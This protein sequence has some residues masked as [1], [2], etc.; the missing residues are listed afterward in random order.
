MG[1]LKHV[2]LIEQTELQSAIFD[3]AADLH[4]FERGDPFKPW[5]GA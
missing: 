3:Q 2:S 1:Q 4:T 5:L